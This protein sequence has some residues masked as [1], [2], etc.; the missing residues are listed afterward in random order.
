[1]CG[2]LGVAAVRGTTPSVN[3]EDVTRMRDTMTRRGPDSAGLWCEENV[4]LAHR[5][6]A[7]LDPTPAGQQPMAT[8][9]GRYHL[10]YDGQLYNDAELRAELLAAGAVPG[11]FRSGCD[12]ETV[13][14]AFATW[15]TAV[16]PRLRGM[17][18][19]AIYDSHEHV[20]HLARDPL[21]MKPLYYHLGPRELTFASEP[22]AILAHP[23]IEALPDL[24]MASAYLSTL[25]SCLGSRTLFRGLQTL[26]P[27]ERLRFEARTGRVRQSSFR[28][29]VP[30][31]ADRHELARS[32]REVREGVED[33]LARH[34]RADVPVAALLSGGL[35]SSILCDIATRRGTELET[36]CTGCRDGETREE[37]FDYA[38][39]AAAAIGTRH[40][41]VEIDE[42]RFL[43]DWSWMVGELGLPLSTPNEIAIQAVARALRRDGTV[44]ALSGEGADELFAGYELTMQAAAVHAETPSD[45]RSGG[46]YQLDSSSWVALGLKHYL[47]H[48][49]VLPAVEG[50]A[51]LIG[52]YDELFLRCER[53]AGPEATPLDAHLRFMRHGNL[54]G[55]LQRLDTACMLASV[56]SRTP[57][58]DQEVAALADALPMTTKLGELEPV[59]AG[60]T[61]VASAVRGK[62]VLRRAWRNRLP[63]AVLDRPKA[64]FPPVFQRWMTKLAWKLETSPFARVCYSA[65]ARAEVARD[66][67]RHWQLAWPMVN[68]ALWGDR[69][70]S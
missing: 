70:W 47:L 8:P 29:P 22:R 58:A 30:V 51:F 17:F 41:E 57:F 62:L 39:Q 13:L 40:R 21:G 15:G 26:E 61:A 7:V 25:R 3:L 20:L 43:R 45:R 65:E 56:E 2:I 69:W 16:F 66:P 28:R 44:V 14:W 4:I 48:R 54:T 24:A 34:L 64:S 6:L 23:A 33:S 5:R 31:E 1:M 55:L 12:T 18:A 38:R 67:V 42:G 63:A 59:G 36:W 27:G 9:D 46:R 49:D 60:G 52:H 35:D 19:L 53:E 10:V 50:D 11:G 32:A 37:D 68:L